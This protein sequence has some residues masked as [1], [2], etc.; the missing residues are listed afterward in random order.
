MRGFRLLGRVEQISARDY[1]ESDILRF[2]PSEDGLDMREG[3][4]RARDFDLFQ[5]Q[6]HVV[7]GLCPSDYVFVATTIGE[8]AFK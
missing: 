8:D 2:A 5:C 7:M 4:F 1:H 3:A 6:T